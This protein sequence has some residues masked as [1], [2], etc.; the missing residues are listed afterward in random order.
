[1]GRGVMMKALAIAVVVGVCSAV[2]AVEV[3]EQQLKESKESI[4]VARNYLKQCRADD[5]TVSVG[6]LGWDEVREYWKKVPELQK[7]RDDFEKAD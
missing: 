3:D 1:M 6:N 4:K 2:L 7:L 5:R